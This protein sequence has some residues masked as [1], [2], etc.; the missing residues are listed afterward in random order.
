MSSHKVHYDA[1]PLGHAKLETTALSTRVA[2][3]TMR[4]IKSRWSDSAST[5]RAD[6]RPPDRPARRGPPQASP[7]SAPAD[8]DSDQNT[9]APM[10]VLRRPHDHRRNVRWPAPRPVAIA[11]LDQDRRLMS[12]AALTA[13][14]PRFPSPPPRPSRRP[15]SSPGRP[16]SFDRHACARPAYPRDQ[17]R[18]PSSVP[19]ARLRATRRRADTPEPH[20]ILKPP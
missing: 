14:Q 12:V 16:C 5:S 2:V 13:S 20:A 8:A 7:G 19:L 17:T 1:C 15:M 18:S 3:N 11:N 6:R 4:D 10:P 9:C